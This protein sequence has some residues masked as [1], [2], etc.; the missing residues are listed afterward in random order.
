MILMSHES[1]VQDKTRQKGCWLW[2]K[3]N[4]EKKRFC[5][6]FSSCEK[7]VVRNLGFGFLLCFFTKKET[8]SDFSS[9]CF[10]VVCCVE[11]N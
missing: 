6:L 11:S 9:H 4:N 7:L 2:F 5:F 1:F 3:T 10:F 8:V